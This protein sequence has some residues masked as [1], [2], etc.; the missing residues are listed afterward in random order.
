[1]A[2]SDNANDG[3]SLKSYK[4]LLWSGFVFIAASACYLAAAILEIKDKDDPSAEYSAW[5]YSCLGGLGFTVCGIL[6][7]CNEKGYFH[8]FLI[9]AG[10]FGFIAEILDQYS[11]VAS[12]Y[13]NFLS[14]HMY[15]FEAIKVL[16][17]HSEWKSKNVVWIT[18]LLGADFCFF[19]GA[20]IDVVLSYMYVVKSA[21]KGDSTLSQVKSMPELQ[22]ELASGIFWVISALLTMAVFIR[23]G[24]DTAKPSPP[25]GTNLSGRHEIA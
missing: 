11:E 25:T 22:A 24:K 6:E 17:A 5:I 7:F 2:A 10:L 3:L 8:V 19:F 21:G 18:A 13:F 16:K 12:L 4:L 23:I 9:L 20:S 14:N 1:M 15:V